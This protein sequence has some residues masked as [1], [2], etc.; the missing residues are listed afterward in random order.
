MNSGVTVLNSPKSFL[1]LAVTSF[2]LFAGSV[3]VAEE[4]H[5]DHSQHEHDASATEPEVE[6]DPI[7]TL[8]F[9]ETPN[10]NL[11]PVQPKLDMFL[12]TFLLF[13]GFVFI[14]R[15]TTW[16]PLIAG[17]NAREARVVNAERAAA[18]ARQ[19]IEK[20]RQESEARLAETQ[21]RVKALISQARAEAESQ[22]REIVAKAEQDA[23][24]IKSE[25][26]RELQE[27]HQS[28]LE[29]L[30][31]MVDS[32]VALVTEQLVGRRF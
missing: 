13:G 7:S 11:P 9:P 26:L 3:T 31:Q 12:W 25:A 30:D 18:K 6:A 28:A 5:D 14:M 1:C 10:F 32:Q 8:L 4:Y 15:G 21:E 16:G 2:V 24:R 17:I 27:A 23:Q 22:K 19:E 29:S 20:L